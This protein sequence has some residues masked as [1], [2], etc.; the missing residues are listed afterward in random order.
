MIATV[1]TLENYSKYN[2]H[3]ELNNKTMFLKDGLE[4]VLFDEK[5]TSILSSVPGF[6]FCGFGT[7]KQP[8]EYRDLLNLNNEMYSSFCLEM[9][10]RGVRT[11]ERGAWFISIEHSQDILEETIDIAKHAIVALKTK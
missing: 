4:K 7:N 11:L 8:K 3:N 10:K 2:F 6:M 9:I 5:I 1:K